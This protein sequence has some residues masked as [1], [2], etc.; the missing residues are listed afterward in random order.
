[1]K[2]ACCTV[3]FAVL[4]FGAAAQ[5]EIVGGPWL[6]NSRT[7]AITVMWETNIPSNS[8]VDYGLNAELGTETGSPGKT[9]IHEITLTG[10][11]IETNYFYRVRSGNAVS[12]IFQF[13]TAVKPDT[14]FAYVVVG[15]NRTNQDNW[16]RIAALAFAERPNLVLNVGDVVTKG[17]LREQWLEQWILPAAD[18]MA[19]VPM[20]VAIG[21]HEDDSQ[22]FYDYVS[23]PKPEDYYSFDFGNAHF[24]MVDTNKPITPGSEQ[25]EWLEK[26]LANSHATWK[27]VAHHHPPYSSDLNGA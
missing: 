14:A 5:E 6:Q 17:S 7:D 15:D 25:F 19:R 21:N 10:L 1:M 26:D 3:L 27:F 8:Q 4:T 23:Y 13:Q 24:A 18:L 9:V 11:T 2:N 20:Y 22:W 16:A 12:E